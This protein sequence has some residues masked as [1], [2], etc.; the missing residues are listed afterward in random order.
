MTKYNKINT[1]KNNRNKDKTSI[2][3]FLQEHKITIQVYYHKEMAKQR[4]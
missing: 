2:M 3:T 1:Q 4:R